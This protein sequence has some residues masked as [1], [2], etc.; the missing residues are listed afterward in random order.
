MDHFEY[1]KNLVGEDHVAFGPDTLYGD[2]VG[3]H[4]A[5]AESLSIGQ[6]QQSQ[7][8]GQDKKP[9]LEKVEYVEGIEPWGGQRSPTLGRSMV[10][11]GSIP[12]ASDDSHP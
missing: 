9:Q 1:V 6:T 2:H 4:K 8:G 10:A 11:R 5:F 3:L 12:F 7:S